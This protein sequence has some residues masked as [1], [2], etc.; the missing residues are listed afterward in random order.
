MKVGSLIAYTGNGPTNPDAAFH[1]NKDEIFTIR[2]IILKGFTAKGNSGI[3]Y[4]A[5][6]DMLRV[7]EKSFGWDDGVEIASLVTD[8]RE[9][10]PPMDISALVEESITQE[11]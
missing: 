9:L 1:P 10:Q 5:Q 11:A 8:W 7:E 6:W 3:I 4:I 2:E